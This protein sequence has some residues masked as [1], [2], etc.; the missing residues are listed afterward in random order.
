MT[1]YELQTGDELYYR[2]SDESHTIA[3][4]DEHSYQLE[5]SDI[6]KDVV[7]LRRRIENGDIEHRPIRA[8]GGEESAVGQSTTITGR[9]PYMVEESAAELDLIARRNEPTARHDEVRP[10]YYCA[11]LDFVHCNC[12]AEHTTEDV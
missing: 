2:K 9:S 10:G 7:L 3:F 5:G 12:R 1:D 4:I 8:D 6:A 11:D